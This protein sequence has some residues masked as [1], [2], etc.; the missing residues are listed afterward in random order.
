LTS[1]TKIEWCDY[2]INPVKGKCPM[3]CPYCY[4]RRMYD[5]FKWNP[6]IR[7]EISAFDV[8]VDVKVPSRVFVGSTMELFGHWVNQGFL[9]TI[10]SMCRLYPQHTFIF[11][12]KCPEQLSKWSP[13]PKNVWVGASATN[14]EHAIRAMTELGFIEASVKFL[15]LEPLLSNDGYTPW[16]YISFKKV[17]WVIIGRQTPLSAKTMP[18]VSDI[19]EIIHAANE[20]PIPVFLKDKLKGFLPF[21]QYSEPW[22]E[23]YKL[24]QEFPNV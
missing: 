1:K 20:I 23:V 19:R 16:K 24:R 9:R 12:T 3:A 18:R 8:L 21:A 6:E 5:R 7:Y 13:F 2:T 22:K 15:S 10:F 4:A 14:S 11:L 17:N